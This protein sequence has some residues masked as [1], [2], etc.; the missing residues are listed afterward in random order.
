ML[1]LKSGKLYR[2]LCS[3]RYGITIR[4][5]TNNYLDEM[6]KED[7]FLVINQIENELSYSICQ[8]LFKDITGYIVIYNCEK[9][10][11][12]EL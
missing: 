2:I 3:Q 8:I 7:I 4:S 10:N 12:I 5:R 11:F 6:N 9:N 1:S